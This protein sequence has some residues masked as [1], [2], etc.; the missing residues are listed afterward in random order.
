M[1]FVTLAL[2]PMTA[3]DLMAVGVKG[4]DPAVFFSKTI[5]CLAASRASSWFS[6][7]QTS[8]GPRFP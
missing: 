5:P 1:V 4:S 3:N 6:G 2:G 8:L 7:V